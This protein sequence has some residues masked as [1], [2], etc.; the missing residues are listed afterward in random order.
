MTCER[1]SPVDT[2]VSGEEGQEGTPGAGDEIPLYPVVRPWCTPAAHGEPCW[3][4]YPGI[5]CWS[6]LFAGTCRPTEAGACRPCHGRA[7]LS[8]RV[9]MQL[10]DEV[11]PS[12]WAQT[13]F[14]HLATQWC[15]LSSVLGHALRGWDLAYSWD[16]SLKGPGLGLFMGFL[17]KRSF[18]RLFSTTQVSETMQVHTATW[19][20][21]IQARTD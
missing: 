4:R 14:F 3:S 21:A 10:L 9:R 18:R 16:S 8:L 13:G 11:V 19:V 15:I 7:L 1:N 5:P 20:L 12:S 17:F 2:N 6:R